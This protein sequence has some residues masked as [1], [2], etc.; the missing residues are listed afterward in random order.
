[1]LS[2]ADSK[3]EMIGKVMEHFSEVSEAVLNS[4]IPEIPQLPV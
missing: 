3:N 4:A 2:G 1:M